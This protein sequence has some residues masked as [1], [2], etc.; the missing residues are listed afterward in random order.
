MRNEAELERRLRKA[1][2]KLFDS[3][4]SLRAGT[5]APKEADAIAAAIDE[6]LAALRKKRI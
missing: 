2:P 4:D 3:L 5:L 6:E 1:R